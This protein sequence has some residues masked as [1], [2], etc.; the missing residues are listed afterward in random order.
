MKSF[1]LIIVAI[2]ISFGFNTLNAQTYRLNNK[3]SEVL[4]DGTSNIHDWT[5]EAESASGTISL[6]QNGKDLNGISKLEFTVE[7]ES[8]KSGK[9]GMDKNTYKALNTDDHKLITYQLKEV[10]NIEKLSDNS[11]KVSTTGIME[12]AGT[13][14]NIR[15]D[16]NLKTNSN[17]IS[18]SGEHNL[19]MTDY[20]VEPPTAMFGTITTGDTVKIKFKT[21]FS[22]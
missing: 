7:A 15:L 11:Y 22:I 4:V 1:N 19:K 6:N 10:N 2:L 8:L 12:I 9:G 5:I 14:K 20:G 13:K 17:T 3:A 18:L 16:F 21:Q